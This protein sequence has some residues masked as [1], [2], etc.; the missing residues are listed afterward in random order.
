MRYLFLMSFCLAACGEVAMN[1]PDA[2]PDA[3]ECP[4]SAPEWPDARIDMGECQDTGWALII[5]DRWQFRAPADSTFLIED[6]A[7]I[8]NTSNAEA[9]YTGLSVDVQTDSLIA[10]FDVLNDSGTVPAGVARGT[11]D[12]TLAEV[13][14][15]VLTEPLSTGQPFYTISG[16]A[17]SSSVEHRFDIDVS[18]DGLPGSVKHSVFVNTVIAAAPQLIPI[19]AAR[20]CA[21]L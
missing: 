7:A 12:S 21:T 10:F 2:A 9:V 19:T 5:V 15:D 3:H 14:V 18:F 8:A 11:L 20:I 6:F 4:D 13:L 16:R 1:P 17:V